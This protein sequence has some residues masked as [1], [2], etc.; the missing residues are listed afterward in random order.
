MKQWMKVFVF[1]LVSCVSIVFV[2]S[3]TEAVTNNSEFSSA[4]DVKNNT[5]VTGMLAED[6]LVD[7][8]KV[9]LTSKANL[10]FTYTSYIHDSYFSI[11]DSNGQKQLEK[12]VYYGS[13]SEPKIYTY[14]ITLNPG[15]YYVKVSATG[16]NSGKYLLK[17]QEI[18][19]VSSI[20]ISNIKTVAVGKTFKLAAS[21]LPGNA[22]NKTLSWSS[23]NSS[24]AA[25]DSVS[26]LV[27]AYAAGTAVITA[28]AQD[29]SGAQ[30]SVSV[31]VKP[32]KV[33]GLKVTRS[34]FVKKALNVTW[35]S[36]SSVTGYQIKYA[37]N[38][39]FKSAKK[40]SSK[41]IYATIKKLKKKK[42][43]F[44]KVRSYVKI[45]SKKYYGAWSTVK[46]CKVK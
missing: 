9:T 13:E 35:D 6:D 21:V 4:A 25:V 24:V 39:K 31:I 22:A 40:K 43:Y 45:G 16:K 42:K 8:Y 5:E 41:Y 36:Q 2:Q 29:G 46:K 10:I 37:R 30:K 44:V 18:V 28:T 20:T 38:K 27:T 7:C 26:G 19:K 12:N 1:V 14:E 15:I 34:K 17:Y 23:D 32:G 3:K 33:K 11:W